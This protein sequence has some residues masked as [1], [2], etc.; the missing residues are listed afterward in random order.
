LIPAGVLVTMPDPVPFKFT[1]KTGSELRVKLATTEALAV[2]VRLQAPVPLQAPDHPAKM[3]FPAGLAVRVTWVPEAK[4]P[5]QV[6][7]QLI[8]AGTL[9]T[10]PVPVPPRPTLRVKVGSESL[11]MAITEVLLFR[12]TEQVPVP[13]QAP[14][15]PAKVEFAAGLAVRVTC[16]PELK[17]ALQVGAQLIPAGKLVTMPV[18]A[19]PRPTVSVNVGSEF[20]LNMAITEVLLFRVT[21]QVPVP[22][23]APPHPAKVEVGPAAAVRVTL[24]PDL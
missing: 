15:H 9:V 20:S 6:G 12:V 7:A 22:L 18:P 13:L 21:A 3:E 16:V 14:A 23:Q 2:K 24:V 10:R 1:L 19:P 17:L 8:P 4:R 5:L 11:N